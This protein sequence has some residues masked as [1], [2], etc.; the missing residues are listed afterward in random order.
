M[1]TRRTHWGVPTV[2]AGLVGTA[3]ARHLQSA[4]AVELQRGGGTLQV[5]GPGLG[6]AELLHREEHKEGENPQPGPSAVP[7]H[8]AVP[9]GC[10]LPSP[11]ASFGQTHHRQWSASGKSCCF[12]SCPLL[13]HGASRKTLPNLKPKK[14]KRLQINHEMSGLFLFLFSLF[15][16][17]FNLSA[18]KY[19]RKGLEPRCFPSICEAFQWARY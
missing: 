2:T 14:K 3:G 9:P 1:A 6:A 19:R 7:R 5:P 18:F 17:E 4:I 10:P 12:F 13:F 16:M 8:G 15:L 11:M